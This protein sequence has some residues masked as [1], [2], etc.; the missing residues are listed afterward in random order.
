MIQNL[1]ARTAGSVGAQTFVLRSALI[2]VNFVIMLGL[3][4]L[5]G[6]EAYGAL[7]VAW[8]LTLVM[9][10][11]LSV[12]GPLAMLRNLTNGGVMSHRGLFDQAILYPALVAAVCWIVLPRWLPI[13][14]WQ[15]IIPSAF[16]INAVTCLASLARA[17]GSIRV[18]MVL[19]DGA[20]QLALGLA[21]FCMLIWP[22][23]PPL[24]IIGVAGAILGLVTL[25]GLY[26]C[27]LHPEFC[28]IV[29]PGRAVLPIETGLWGASV[30]GMVLAQI[31][32]IVGSRFL[33]GDQI[34]LYALLKRIANL[35]ALP[36]SVATWITA[37]PVSA[38]FGAGDDEGL[39][40]ASRRGSRVALVPGIL[41][42]LTAVFALPF[43]PLDSEPQGSLI[44][45][46]LLG[47]AMVQVVF[48]SSFTVAN[49]CGGALHAAAA[50]IIS[51]CVYMLFAIYA[52]VELSPLV[53]AVA[54]A[55]G[56]AVGSL[57]LWAVIWER[58]GVDTSAIALLR[59]EA[60]IWKPS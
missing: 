43:L 34:G 31:D 44:Y 54:Y 56:T 53:N 39:Q 24:F 20:P 58:L 49:L 21:A 12:G 38:A 32:I 4:A 13:A 15:I 9:S 17:L 45:L 46:T 6:L 40:A 7:M 55:V 57:A 26:R 3:A 5:L 51:I 19:R 16:F 8:G 10:T 1:I 23:L 22:F 33:S 50:R 25:V 29:E 14:D 47:S 11:I 27:A 37:P 2:G 52:G 60:T 30:L 28:R 41:L 18:S 35:V 48:A 36:V 59:R 42:F